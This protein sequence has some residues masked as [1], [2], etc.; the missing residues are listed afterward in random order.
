MWRELVWR[1][2]T[3]E[4]GPLWGDTVTFNSKYASGRVEQERA[5]IEWMDDYEALKHFI[6]E[7][8]SLP[9]SQTISVPKS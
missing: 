3:G 1:P 9:L 8:M 4:R 5:I 7:C 6:K 2:L